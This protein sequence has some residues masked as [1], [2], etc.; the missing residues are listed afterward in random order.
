MPF[1]PSLSTLIPDNPEGT[2]LRIKYIKKASS[3]FSAV[4]KGL[5]AEAEGKRV[6]V[7]WPCLSAH[8]LTALTGCEP[9]CLSSAED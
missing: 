8:C 1:C 3:V 4:P 6:S 5:T 2:E 7:V 9:L